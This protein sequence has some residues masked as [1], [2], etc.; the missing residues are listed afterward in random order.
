MIRAVERPSTFGRL[1]GD[2]RPGLLRTSA[3]G[4]ESQCSS[5]G[6]FGYLHME[7]LFTEDE[8]LGV[9][10]D[11]DRAV[12][13]LRTR[14]RSLVVGDAR[15]RREPRR[16]HAGLRRAFARRAELLDDRRSVA[17]RLP[18]DR[19]A[20]GPAAAIA[21]RRSSSRSA[22]SRGSPT[23]PGTRTAASAVTRYDCCSL[24]V[25]ISVTGADDESGQLC[26]RRR[27]APR[28]C[29][30]RS[31][32]PLD[33]PDGACRPRTGDITVHLSCT[34]HMAQPPAERERRVLYTGSASPARSRKAAAEGRARS[35]GPFVEPAPVTVS[36]PPGYTE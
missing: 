19:H 11:M 36:Q 5:R 20:L 3:N 30:P 10:A 23:C 14:R 35:A 18:G 22:S 25:G 32:H 28:S 17:R 21:S 29:G 1:M 13:R 33:L 7:G 4:T 16:P 34:L 24:T 2:A 8:M 12:A 27:V 26:V 15:G 6:P 9:S 31:T